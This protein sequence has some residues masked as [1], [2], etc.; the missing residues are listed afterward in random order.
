M[1]LSRFSPLLGLL[2]CAAPASSPV[3]SAQPEAPAPQATKPT[4]LVLITVDQMRADYLD[5][6][7]SQ[8]SAGLK[9]LVDGGALFTNAHH[10]HAITE[11]APGHASLLSGR[12]PR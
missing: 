1:L 10:D 2:F 12:F 11:T 4:L 5:K 8:F 9:R 3:P 7:K 6:W